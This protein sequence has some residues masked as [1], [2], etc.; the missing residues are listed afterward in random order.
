M[1]INVDIGVS[2]IGY[3][4]SIAQYNVFKTFVFFSIIAAHYGFIQYWLAYK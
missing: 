1:H 4:S 2:I 3:Q